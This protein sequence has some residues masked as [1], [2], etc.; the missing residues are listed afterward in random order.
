VDVNNSNL[1]EKKHI[2][3]SFSIHNYNYFKEKYKNKK[4][5]KQTNSLLVLVNYEYDMFS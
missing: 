3:E 4:R 5:F 1:G 2:R